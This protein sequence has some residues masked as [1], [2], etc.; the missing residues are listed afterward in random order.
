MAYSQGDG[1]SFVPSRP[2][3]A[4]V[5]GGRLVVKGAPEA[6]AA[7]CTRQRFGSD[8]RP[9]DEAG[10]RVLL[11]RVQSLAAQVTQT[12]AGVITAGTLGVNAATAIDL[13]QASNAVSS[14]AAMLASNAT[15]LARLLKRDPL[16]GME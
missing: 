6:L 3:H 10:R 14:K 5:V 7:R 8:E 15:H 1:A 13:G 9:L 11:D 12:S 2:F 4:A 16:P